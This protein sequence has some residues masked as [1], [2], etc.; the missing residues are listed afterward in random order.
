MKCSSGLQRIDFEKESKC[1][2]LVRIHVSE[3]CS[4]CDKVI[5]DAY[6]CF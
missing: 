1:V 2:I 6:G 5:T 4:D 3:Q